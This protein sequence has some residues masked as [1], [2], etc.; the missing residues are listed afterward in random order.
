MYQPD[1]FLLLNNHDEGSACFLTRRYISEASNSQRI[2][3]EKAE[4]LVLHAL[5][6]RAS[7]FPLY[8][9]YVLARYGFIRFPR[10]LTRQRRPQR[11]RS[12]NA[13]FIYFLYYVTCTCTSEYA[14]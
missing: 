9:V 10:Q 8:T 13:L 14:G 5:F 12:C 1:L 11:R 2:K 3:M 6:L 7:I 4:P